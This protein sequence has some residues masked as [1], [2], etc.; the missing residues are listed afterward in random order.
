MLIPEIASL[1]ETIV[2]MLFWKTLKKTKMTNILFYLQRRRKGETEGERER[3]RTKKR[4]SE[5]D[6]KKER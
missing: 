1:K 5:K 3:E 4:G 2:E 6:R